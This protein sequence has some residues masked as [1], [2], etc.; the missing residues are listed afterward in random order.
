VFLTVHSK[1]IYMQPYTH[2]VV[3]ALAGVVLFPH[4]PWAQGACVIGAGLPDVPIALQV[5]VDKLKKRVPFSNEQE[6]SIWFLSKELSHSPLLWI[7]GLIAGFI[8]GG[9]WGVILTAFAVGILSHCAIDALTH[10]H[11]V[12][13]PTDQSL[14]WPFYQM[15]LLP[16]LG[17]VF[18]IWEYRQNPPT[19]IPKALEQIFLVSTVIATI[20]LYFLQSYLVLH[21][22]WVRMVMVVILM[23]TLAAISVMISNRGQGG[24]QRHSVDR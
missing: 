7:S 16:K 6:G 21:S 13:R 20:V 22:F 9:F 8:L 12:F 5:V 17:E 3:G 2:P 24:R 14:A 23:P 11:P 10:C 19:L 4:N 18:G 15:G 1:E